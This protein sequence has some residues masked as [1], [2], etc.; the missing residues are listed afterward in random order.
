MPTMTARRKKRNVRRIGGLLAVALLLSACSQPL[1]TREKTTLGGAG[2]G[3]ATGAIIGAATGSPGVGAAIGG[4]LGGVTGAVVGDKLQ[5]QDV[6]SAD[7]QRQLEEQRREIERQRREL[8][9]LK[10]QQEY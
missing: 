3:A 4:A 6:Q 8:E 1:T 7:Q 2:L 9:D 5:S 10:Q